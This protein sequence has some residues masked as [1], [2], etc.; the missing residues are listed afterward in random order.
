MAECMLVRYAC[1]ALMTPD[2]DAAIERPLMSYID[3]CLKARTKHEMVTHEA[4]RC[5]VNLILYLDKNENPQWAAQEASTIGQPVTGK[6]VGNERRKGGVQHVFG[7]EFQRAIE[8]LTIS[9]TSTK[10]VIRFAGA[11]TLNQLAQHRPELVER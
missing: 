5:F 9:L 11:R 1:Q 4:A 2:R 6:A 8:V 3:S 7:F 10:A